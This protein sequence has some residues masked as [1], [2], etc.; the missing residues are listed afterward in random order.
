MR[1]GFFAYPWD[2]LDEEPNTVIETMATRLHCNAIAL[3]CNYHHARLLRPR[4]RGPKTYQLDGAIAAFV[5]QR[6]RYDAD[7]LTPIPDARL[8]QSR[9]IETTRDLCAAH[10]MDFGL[11]VVGLHNSTLG[12]QHP[13][14]CM[15]NCFGDIYTYAL[16]PS[17]PQA[18]RY[19][20][21][22]VHDVCEQFQPQRIILEAVGYLGMRHGVHHEL[23]MTEWG[24]AL[25]LLLSLC[26]C[27]ECAQRAM[28]AGIDVQTLRERVAAWVSRLLNEESSAPPE[29]AQSEAASLLIEITGLAAYV[30]LCAT[31]VTRLVASV[32]AITQSYRVTLDTIPSSFHRPASRAWI[33][34]APLSQLG[35]VSDELVVLAYFDDA[36]QVTADI[37]WA[38]AL[39][40][41]TALVAGLNVCA[42]N[43]KDNTTL[44]AQAKAAQA[45]ECAAVYYYNYGLL[46]SRRLEWVGLANESLRK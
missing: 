19:L 38:R 25:E 12:T 34:A 20:H 39:A 36:A 6:Q 21:G 40:P 31:S 33:E 18:Q 3:N 24:E 46:T 32:R 29:F 22:L 1:R 30:R 2:L 15:Q 13:D 23:F 41:N 14:V 37:Q 44:I 4:A 16:C 5:P 35:A 45:A 28:Q 9:I 10:G 11:W 17:Q 43:I 8:A 26:F 42:P 7:G 27:R